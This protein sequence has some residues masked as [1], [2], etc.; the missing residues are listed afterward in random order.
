M[1]ATSHAASKAMVAAGAKSPSTPYDRPGR[2]RRIRGGPP[3]AADQ[4]AADPE[5]AR[6]WAGN[7]HGL[8]QVP[9]GERQQGRETPGSPGCRRAPRGPR[10]ASRRRARRTARRGAERGLTGERTS[11]RD[12]LAFAAGQRSGTPLGE[13]GHAEAPEQVRASAP[14][15]ERD[16]ALHREVRQQAVVLRHVADT[17]LLRANRTRRSVSSQTSSPI[18]MRP[19]AARSSP[20]TVRSTHVLP[21]PE[22]PIS[23]S[24]SPIGSSSPSSTSKWRR[25]RRNRNANV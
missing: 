8:E 7:H 25:A 3:R 19:A 6:G 4:V 9:V 21:A 22:R 20:A 17:P 15:P 2:H 16:I 12:P 13:M 11:E 5:P 18:A 24:V 14:R 10:S 23:A 1:S